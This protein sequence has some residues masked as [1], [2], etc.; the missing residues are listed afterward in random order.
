L[1]ISNDQTF[2]QDLGTVYL[3]II[4]CPVASYSVRAD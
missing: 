4:W 3:Q 2:A 1:E